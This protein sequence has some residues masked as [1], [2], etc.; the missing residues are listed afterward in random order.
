MLQLTRIRPGQAP[1]WS[2]V[3]ALWL[4]TRRQAMREVGSLE[5]PTLADLEGWSTILVAELAGEVVGACA[6]RRTT[7]ADLDA[8]GP[9]ETEVREITS[10]ELKPLPEGITPELTAEDAV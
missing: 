4:A 5:E 10:Q 9:V 3:A 6:W 1:L 2:P 8:P 7:E